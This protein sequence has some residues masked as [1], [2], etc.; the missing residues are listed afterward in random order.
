MDQQFC[1]SCGMPLGGDESLLGTNTDGSKNQDYCT[2]CYQNGAFTGE[3]TME[4]MIDFCVPHMVEGNAGM[5]AEEARKQMQAFFP[6]LKRWKTAAN[7]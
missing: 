3:M 2:Y 6:Q 4:E 5:T 7:V 1:G